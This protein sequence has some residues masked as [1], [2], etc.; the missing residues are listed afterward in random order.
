MPLTTRCRHCGRLFPVYAIQLKANRARVPCPQCGKHFDAVAG[1]IDEHVPAV[2]E[3][4]RRHHPAHRTTATPLSAT[5][6]G[7]A[8]EVPPLRRRAGGRAWFGA[9]T[10]VLLTLGLAAQVAWWGRGDWLRHPRVHRVVTD[11][12]QTLGC[13]VPL[14]RLPGTIEILQS[15]LIADP[16]RPETL[17]LRLAMVSRAEVPQRAPVLQLELYD[18]AGAMLAARRF[19]PAEYLAGGTA[20]FGTGLTPHQTVQAALDIALAE[21]LIGTGPAGFRIRLL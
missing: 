11:L 2:D 7:L 12:C 5:A 9:L 8:Q 14:P 10:A 13:E 6:L 20:T 4:N 19:D 21:A 1:L 17:R 15:A 3:T 18:P 16:I